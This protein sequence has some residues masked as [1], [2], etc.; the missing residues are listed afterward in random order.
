MEKL[1][2]LLDKLFEK[3]NNEIAFVFEDKKNKRTI[4][5]QDKKHF[6]I[7]A[8]LPLAK[9]DQVLLNKVISSNF[10]EKFSYDEEHKCAIYRIIF[11]KERSKH[12]AD[13]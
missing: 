2:N 12:R 4:D 13:A 6:R 5:E 10:K 7:I 9:C 8:I 1:S 11:I 3:T